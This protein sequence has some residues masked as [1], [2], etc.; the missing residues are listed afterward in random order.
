MILVTETMH[1]KNTSSCSESDAL[2]IVASLI[3]ATG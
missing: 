3:L 1:K 2:V